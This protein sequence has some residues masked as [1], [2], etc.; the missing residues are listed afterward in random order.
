MCVWLCTNHFRMYCV[1][2][3][4]L[5]RILTTTA[6]F[7]T[8]NGKKWTEK[9]KGK[10]KP[11]AR[12]PSLLKNRSVRLINDVGGQ[13]KNT[14]NKQKNTL[15]KNLPQPQPDQTLQQSDDLMTGVFV[16][17]CLW[18]GGVSMYFECAHVHTARE[19][20]KYSK[21][22]NTVFDAYMGYERI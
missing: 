20:H 4:V 8:L 11:I 3:W 15:P 19:N 16:D 1:C 7:G 5:S 21:Y 6:G 2:L 12:S 10:L 13:N 18:V 9:R 17:V 22:S 14:E